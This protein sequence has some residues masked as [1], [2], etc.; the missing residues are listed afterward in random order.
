MSESQ[1]EIISRLKATITKLPE[2]DAYYIL[3]RAEGM[4]EANQAKEVQRNDNLAA[5]GHQ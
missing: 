1:K 2:R 3:G 4:A 5:K